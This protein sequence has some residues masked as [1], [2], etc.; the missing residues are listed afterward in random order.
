MQ[1]AW[2]LLLEA[3]TWAHT[4]AKRSSLVL[5]PPNS[6]FNGCKQKVDRSIRSVHAANYMTILFDWTHPQLEAIKVYYQFVILLWAV[7]VIP[8]CAILCTYSHMDWP[9]VT[10]LPQLM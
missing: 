2:P 5:T 4:M 3:R 10:W 1:S 8:T 6:I 9:Y 7:L